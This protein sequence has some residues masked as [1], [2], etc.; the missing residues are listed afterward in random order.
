MHVKNTAVGLLLTA[1]YLSAGCIACAGEP[2]IP[3]AP[4]TIW[5]TQSWPVSTP[6][7]QGMD[8]AGLTRLVETV[9]GS[10]QD[11]LTIIRHGKI[12][13]DAYYAPHTA[14]ITHD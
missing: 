12:V 3:T 13:A 1:F 10:R 5:P 14:G 11:S 4:E 2:G 6:E 9:G 8:S 7:E